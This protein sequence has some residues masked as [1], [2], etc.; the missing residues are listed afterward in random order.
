[1]KADVGRHG[2][3]MFD[4]PKVFW[5]EIYSALLPCNDAWQV[6]KWIVGERLQIEDRSG[7]ICI[8]D[9][10]ALP[11]ESVGAYSVT[12]S[13]G[14]FYCRGGNRN[15]IKDVLAK[16]Y[17]ESQKGDKPPEGRKERR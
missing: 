2:H 6:E 14:R 7:G 17:S 4:V 16:A 13:E 8:V 1:M 10:F 11:D 9:L 12:S 3:Q 15:R 5:I